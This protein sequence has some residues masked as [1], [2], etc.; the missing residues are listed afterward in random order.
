MEAEQ[1]HDSY[2]VV[3][4]VVA[5]LLVMMQAPTVAWME[6]AI[7]EDNCRTVVMV[8]IVATLLFIFCGSFE[9]K[10]GKARC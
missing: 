7:P 10:I 2:L 9:V 5:V 1:F 3:A 6:E 4:V 8:V